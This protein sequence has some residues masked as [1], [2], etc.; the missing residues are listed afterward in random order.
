MWQEILRSVAG[1][2]RNLAIGIATV[3]WIAIIALSW[4]LFAIANASLLGTVYLIMS[5]CSAYSSIL[6]ILRRRR[7]SSKSSGCSSPEGA[8]DLTFRTLTGSWS[9]I[10]IRNHS[11]REE[12]R[13]GS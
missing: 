3:I 7:F 9:D 1:I 4:I 5:S 6:D 13:N 12:T 8:S 10:S 2:I 11:E